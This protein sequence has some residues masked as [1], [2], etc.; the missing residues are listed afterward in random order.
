MSMCI[1]IFVMKIIIM[2]SY[3]SRIHFTVDWYNIKILYLRNF[4]IYNNT[5]LNWSELYEL[6]AIT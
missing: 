6:N 2:Q 3:F 1:Y 5:L 4:N